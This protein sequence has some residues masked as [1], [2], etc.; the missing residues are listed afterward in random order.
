MTTKRLKPNFLLFAKSFL[1]LL[2]LFVSF[3]YFQIKFYD[4]P[5]PE[6]FSGAGWYNP[7][8]DLG[9]H[10]YKSNF[11]THAHAWNGMTN[12]HQPGNEVLEAYYELG[13][14]IPCISDYFSINS[15]LDRKDESFI[16][17]YE[18]GIN[19]HKSHRQAIGSEKVCFYD[20]M[21]FQNQDIRQ[22][23]IERVKQT[24]PLLAINHPTM[25]NSHPVE[26]MPYLSGYDLLEVINSFRL[27]T[28][29]WDAAL[30]SGHPVW[31][32]ANDD[33]H[34][35]ERHNKI[36]KAWTMVHAPSRKR[37]DV[38][39]ALGSGRSYGVKRVTDKNSREEL[40]KTF[41]ITRHKPILQTVNIKADTFL[42]QLNRPVDHV[43]LIGQG[44]K[45][46]A[47]IDETD[48]VAYLMQ[49]DDTYVRAELES[50]ELLY[51]LN[52]IVRHDGQLPP[53]NDM[54][55]KMQIWKTFIWRI[56]IVM[57]NLIVFY[58]LYR[59]QLERLLLLRR[60][61]RWRPATA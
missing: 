48:Q 17:V 60:A 39:N 38:L 31:L 45:T 41:W 9:Q 23:L 43:R 20:V 12:G 6:P 11:H 56:G 5:E 3:Q 28:E 54:E 44:G 24:A 29:H 36:A 18:H 42:L 40:L 14:D 32:L 26:M 7:Y 47:E 15:H 25:K 19:I 46:L 55:A 49:P 2:I 8:K 1:F 35:V 57:F 34:D 33:C 50:G 37:E 58:L 51:L 30:S 53:V 13:Y 4:Y 27:A 61:R 10:W 16:P 21:L 22:Y 59:P 52:P